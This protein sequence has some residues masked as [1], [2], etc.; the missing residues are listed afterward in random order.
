M[1]RTLTAF[2]LATAFIG[3]ASAGTD[4]TVKLET[5]KDRVQKIVAAK[6]LWNCLDDTCNATL[7]RKTVKI[8]TC[9]QVVKEIGKVADFSNG[10]KSLSDRDLAKCN[11]VA[12]S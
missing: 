8:S 1:T 4:F 10:T 2:I 5:P 11:A 6:A 7:D 3:S 9:K 12:K